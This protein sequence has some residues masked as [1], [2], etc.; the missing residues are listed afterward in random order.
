[1]GKNTAKDFVEAIQEDQT[2]QAKPRGLPPMH[3]KEKGDWV[4][5]AE[6]E[7]FQAMMSTPDNNLLQLPKRNLKAHY[8]KFNIDNEDQR[9][10][11]EHIQNMCITPGSGWILGREEWATDSEGNT[12]IVVKYLEPVEKDIKKKK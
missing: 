12:H 4:N 9:E 8:R 2:Q 5:L 3:P 11:L 6:D 1:M 7:E 10:K